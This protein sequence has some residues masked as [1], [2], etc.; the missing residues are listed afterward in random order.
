MSYKSL[1]LSSSLIL[2][3]LSSNV[4]AQFSVN[5]NFRA[6]G[7]FRDGA[8]E[9]L[10]KDQDA[11]FVVSQRTRLLT[12]YKKDRIELQM[13][14]QNARIWGVEADR[15]NTGNINLSEG[16]LRYQLGDSSKFYV[17]TGRQ[18]LVLDDGRIYGMRNWNDIAVSHDMLLLEYVGDQ[19][20]MKLAGAYNNDSYD[21]Y[22][23][24]YET[25]FYKYMG[26]LWLNYAL[27][28]QWQGSFLQSVDGRENPDDHTETHTRFTSGVYFQKDRG[29]SA[30]ALKSSFYYQYGVH[31]NGSTVSAYMLSILPAITVAEKLTTTFGV[32]YF[33]GNEVDDTSG[34]YKAFNKLFGDAH[35]YYGYMDYFL[36]IEEDAKGAGLRE[37]RFEVDY[38][39]NPKTSLEIVATNFAVAGSLID[40]T[41]PTVP[42]M[43][44][45]NLGTEVDVQFTHQLGEK[46]SLTVAY[47]RM[48]AKDE[49]EVLK[50]GDASRRQQWANI[51]LVATPS[52]F[53]SKSK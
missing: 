41:S 19:L 1:L 44:D 11:A 33:S 23:Q 17:K 5:A 18:H 4:Q 22:K 16:W 10:S 2:F 29:E 14:F 8:R 13:S 34:K 3:L 20:Y 28:K 42:Y 21:T 53:N 6:R 31:P 52:L 12:N 26:V 36:N 39:F 7:E 46:V 50:G 35:R 25:N 48:F 40:E 32:N 30:F 51:M 45:G 38:Q 9:L 24:A 43:V 15:A 49:M 27:N 37:L 47:A